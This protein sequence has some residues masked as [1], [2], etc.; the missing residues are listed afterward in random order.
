MTMVKV[1]TE[2]GKN[3]IHYFPMREM[4]KG[5][6]CFVRDKGHYVIRVDHFE[7]K[8]IF[9]ILDNYHDI[10]SYSDGCDLMVRALYDGESITIK[11]C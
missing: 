1:Q 2:E 6:V 10:D 8:Q 7:Q 4:K 5:Q 9:L 3:S 11:F